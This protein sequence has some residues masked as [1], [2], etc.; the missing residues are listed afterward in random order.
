MYWTPD[1][2]RILQGAE[3][4]LFQ[5]SLGMVGDLLSD[6][7]CDFDVQ[8]FDELQRG[9]KLFALYQAGRALLAPDE[10][11]PELSAFLE[12][13]V[14]TIYRFALGRVV[15][16][17]EEPELAA[18]NPSWRSMVLDT[19]RQRD[20]IDELPDEKS[21]D[22]SEWQLMV[23][24]LESAVLWDNDFEVQEGM[25]A[26]PDASYTVKELLGIPENYYTEVPLDVA[27]NQ[28]NLYIDALKGLTPRGREEG[29]V[30]EEDQNGGELF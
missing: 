16:E 27:D 2:E 20:D 15:Q 11:M 10:P 18:A 7:D 28:L 22:L 24:C 30:D 8:V 14:A 13:A 17:V 9:Q 25:D 26:D 3:R 5:E 29:G 21:S 6:G 1:G 23:E 19:I 4:R 12:G